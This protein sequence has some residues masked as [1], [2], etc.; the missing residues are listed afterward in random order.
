MTL[1]KLR[2]NFVMADLA[3]RFKTS[4]SQVSKTVGMWIDI[5]SEHTNNLIMWLPRETIKATLPQAFKEH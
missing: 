5:M 2:Q 1:M 3:R 4:Q